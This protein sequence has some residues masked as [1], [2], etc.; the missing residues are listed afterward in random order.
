MNAFK[1]LSLPFWL[2]NDMGFKWM[3]DNNDGANNDWNTTYKFFKLLI[4]MNRYQ[5]LN[6]YIQNFELFSMSAASVND[7]LSR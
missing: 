2:K 1:Y 5:D 7:L 4:L 3:V 6:Q